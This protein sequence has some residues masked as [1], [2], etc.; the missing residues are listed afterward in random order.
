MIIV[1][2][3]FKNYKISENGGEFGFNRK[4]AGWKLPQGYI[5]HCGVDFT[6]DLLIRSPLRGTVIRAELGH[7]YYGN[8]VDIT[9]NLKYFGDYID[10]MIV[11]RFNHLDYIG[12]D[13]H[14]GSLIKVGDLVGKM[15][16]TGSSTGVHLHLE[17]RQRNI[18][19]KRRTVL[20]EDM[21]G[22]LE[23]DESDLDDFFKYQWGN[24]YIDPLLFL[25]YVKLVTELE[26]INES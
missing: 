11:M 18:K 5:Y 23:L 19:P 14:V 17:V 6:G 25:D 20:M 21:T 24:L 26:D 4:E 7:R 2:N 15:G 12:K 9:F 16:T 13:I 1:L 8:F 22:R 10:Q 3:Y